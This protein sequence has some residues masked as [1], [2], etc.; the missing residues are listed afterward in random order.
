MFE[1]MLI[2][3]GNAPSTG[4]ASSLCGDPASVHEKMVACLA[5]LDLLDAGIA[6]AHLALAIDHLRVQFNLAQDGSGTD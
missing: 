5:A 2:L 4:Q 6:A 3:P 1:F